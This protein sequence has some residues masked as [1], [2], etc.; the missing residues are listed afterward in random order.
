MAAAR[1][2]ANRNRED[3]W[4]RRRHRQAPHAQRVDGP[5][6][7][8]TAQLRSA[9]GKRPR[10]WRCGAP[11]T[12]AQRGRSEWGSARSEQRRAPSRRNPARLAPLP[13]PRPP[14]PA[15]LARPPRSL[16]VPGGPLSPLHAS[17]LAGDHVI[18]V[19]GALPAE[20]KLVRPQGTVHDPKRLD[21]SLLAMVARARCPGRRGGLRRGDL[22]VGHG[23]G[24]FRVM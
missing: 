1:R 19:I 16:P 17:V 15:P 8:K 14:R 6:G 5:R 9:R 18:E 7:R 4:N 13:S 21:G 20:S 3:R 10:T 2:S 11:H 22:L 24:S 23:V 12:A